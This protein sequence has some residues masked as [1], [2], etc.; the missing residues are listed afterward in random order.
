[1]MTD[2]EITRWLK[3]GAQLCHWPDNVQLT[4]E[5]FA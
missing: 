5:T 1:M 4:T 2:F 3:L